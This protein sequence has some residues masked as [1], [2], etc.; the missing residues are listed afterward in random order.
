MSNELTEENAFEW[1]VKRLTPIDEIVK[2][3]EHDVHKGR[4]VVES[5]KEWV[6]GLDPDSYIR[7]EP[8]PELQAEYD[9]YKD[10]CHE[11]AD[12]KAV[13]MRLLERPRKNAHPEDHLDRARAAVEWADAAIRAAKG[14]LH[15]LTTYQNVYRTLQSINGHIQQADEAITSGSN[16]VRAVKEQLE[17]EFLRHPAQ[18]GIHA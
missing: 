1:T 9:E 18:C 15:V 12:K 13:Y 2:Q 11:F 10:A 5:L 8:P 16:A 6:A 14:R 7:F 17:C 3:F 4:L